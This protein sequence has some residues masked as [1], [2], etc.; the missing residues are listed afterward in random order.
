VETQFSKEVYGK[1]LLQSHD[2]RPQMEANGPSTLQAGL[3]LPIL[4][5]LGSFAGW[6]LLYFLPK[7]MLIPQILQSLYAVTIL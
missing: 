3:N 5:I 2:S 7:D 4:S 6:L 1:I